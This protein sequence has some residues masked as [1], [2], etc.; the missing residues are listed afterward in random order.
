M[1]NTQDSISNRR[2]DERVRCFQKTQY[3]N[4]SGVRLRTEILNTSSGGARLTTD[5]AV[6]SGDLLRILNVA[7]NGNVGDVHAE[8]R[9]VAP[10]PGGTRLLVGVKKIEF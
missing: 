10:L 4:A 2:N 8:V 1:H 7:H 3:I 9:W 5:P 6:K